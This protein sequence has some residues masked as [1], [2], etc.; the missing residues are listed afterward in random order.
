MNFRHFCLALFLC[1]LPFCAAQDYSGD[2]QAFIQEHGKP[3]RYVLHIAKTEKELAAKIDI[4]TTFLFDDP[5]DS[6][7]VDNSGLC[8]RY[9][10]VTFEGS[11]SPEDQS[12][13]GH[14]SLGG[15]QQSITWQRMTPG[16][17]DKLETAARRLR[18][19]MFL[20]A[21]NWKV[22]AGDTPHGESIDLDDSDW[23][24]VGPNSY[25]PASAV[26]Y[27]RWIE[28]PRTLNGYDVTGAKVW[29]DF[30]YDANGPVTEI[31]YFNG[32]RV[33]MGEDLEP[34]VLLERAHPGDKVLIAVKLQRSVDRK[35]FLA[36]RVRLEYPG[37]RPDPSKL[38]QEMGAVSILASNSELPQQIDRELAKSAAAVDLGALAGA[39][40]HAFDLSL[41]NSFELIQPLK[42]NMRQSSIR[43]TGNSHI[44]AAWLW[45][46]T[47]T[48]DVVRRTFGTALQL[49]EEYPQAT[50]TQSAAAYSEWMFEK[51]PFLHQQIVDRVR[52]GR[53]EMV[54]GMWVEPDL[55]MPDGESLVR[56]L[57]IGKRFIKDKF[58]VDVRIGWNPDS[59]GYNWQLPQIY[60]KSGIDYFVTQK[61]AWNDTNQLPLKLFWWQS[62]DG[63][64]VLTYFPHDYVNEIEPLRMAQ[65]LRTSQ[66]LN[67]G[68]SDMMHLFGMGDH[69]GGMTRSMLDDGV[70]WSN[71]DAIFPKTGF[72]VAQGF[73]SE[74]E[75]KVD[76]EHAPVW[77][78]KTLATGNAQLPPAAKGKISLPV[79]N[80]ELYFEY[81]RG[82]FTTQA[83]HKRNMRES[84][85][86]LLDAEKFSSLAWLSGRSYP[87]TELTAAWK[88]VLFKQFHDLAAGSG[89]GQ[90]YRDAQRDYDSVHLVSEHA[91]S[92]ARRT[93]ESQID[94]RVPPGGVPI[95]VFNSLAWQR[96]DLVPVEV[97]LPDASKGAISVVNAEGQPQPVQV[98]A[99]N[100][101]LNTYR[102]LVEAKNVPSLGYRVLHVLPSGK[103]VETDLRVDG[104]TLEDA[105]LR[106]QVD[107]KTGCIT[108]LYDKRSQFESIA[109][110]G[111]GNELIAF[112]DKPR[113]YDAWNIDRDFELHFT[114]LDA[115][116]SVKVVERGPV[117]ATIRVIRTW[118]QSKFVQDI[119][120]YAGLDRVDVHNEFD[121]HES[122]ILLKA[123]F[124]LSS[125]SPEA[126]YEIPYGTIA[127][128]TTRNNLFESAKFEVPALRFA[129]LGDEQHGFSLINESKYGYDAKGNVLRIS[130]LRSPTWPDPDADRGHHSFSYSLYPHSGNWKQALAVRRGYEFNYK[131][132][133]RQVAAHPGPLPA[134]HSF[135]DVKQDHVILTA[136]KKA[137]DEDAI[138]LRFYEWAGTGGDVQLSIP[139]GTTAAQ[140]TDLMEKPQETRLLVDNGQVIV[141]VHPYEIVSIRLSYT[142]DKTAT[143]N[144]PGPSSSE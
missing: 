64:R 135:V 65:D 4:P 6:I 124:P 92:Q 113:D 33:G 125:S 36:A 117:R 1:S 63:S 75:T 11:L 85:E 78:Y 45:P 13:R 28:I 132:T 2:W 21:E 81:H 24:V 134:V 101:T 70:R 42:S 7:S 30:Q 86:Q 112:Q 54:G 127:R 133:A 90:I 118:Q 55:N 73:F 77:S 37:S 110:H 80:D 137:E 95:V 50:Y 29:F 120:L 142:P 66:I 115:A 108:S 128:P 51:Y 119:S 106:V 102:L 123:A 17:G 16:A 9:G 14:W 44:D 140:V 5:V 39:D 69:G 68:I 98:L 131:L 60:K 57:L 32:N 94:T 99:E 25:S 61:M 82:V 52:E 59:F 143:E 96:T 97:Q 15:E 91:T 89:I 114:K 46:W 8:V 138:L 141:P 56:Q 23:E 31:L 144:S 100:S 139:K 116:D 22:H 79:W 19:L 67:P 71:P 126:T 20:P 53:W 88:K 43:M 105:S 109:A 40:Q 34:M 136:L 104:L 62:P 93:L 121:W 129:D 26:W 35:H 130:L 111:C 107:P 87:S 47:D 18:S 122:H 83:Q 72:G 38:F 49:M 103:P 48:V 3:V 12:I 84:E 58:G 27:R 10:Q 41:S 74:V 76:G